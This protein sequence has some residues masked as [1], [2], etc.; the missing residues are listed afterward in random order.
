MLT[1]LKK[2]ISSFLGSLTGY[3]VITVFLLIN[4]LFLWVFEGDFNI[5]DFGFANLDGLFMIGPFVFLF[6]IPAITMR[7]F[8]EEKRT[9]TIEMI[10]TKPLTELEIVM[11]KFLSGL[12]LVIFSL[13][14]TLIYFFSVYQLGL[15]KG[16][17]DVGG[18]WGSYIGLLFLGASFVAVGMFAST[19]TDNQIVSFILAVFLCGFLYIGFDL[20]HSFDLFGKAD[21][22]I[23]SLGINEHYKSMSRGVL[24]TRDMIYFLGV[25]A[26]F[27]LL[28]RFSIERRKW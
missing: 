7:L 21:L 26:L 24:D 18:M 5:L 15:P 3:I 25:I 13:L 9:G 11:A 6:L 28:S 20:I 4:G 16:N 14:P 10:L 8:A 2:E 23:K 27:I 17:L 22:F 19:L 12:V 1:L